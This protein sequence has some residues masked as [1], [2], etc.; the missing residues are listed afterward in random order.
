MGE[1]HSK[2]LFFY[3]SLKCHLKVRY[4]CGEVSRDGCVYDPVT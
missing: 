1:Y 3:T 2:D 4:V